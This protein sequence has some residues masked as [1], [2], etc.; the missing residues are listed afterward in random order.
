MGEDAAFVFINIDVKFNRP[1]GDLP[2]VRL[3]VSGPANYSFKGR[4]GPGVAVEQQR[5]TAR[6]PGV[7]V[8]RTPKRDNLYGIAVL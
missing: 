5:A 2:R 3:M 8:I 7:R 1:V 4:L 6:A